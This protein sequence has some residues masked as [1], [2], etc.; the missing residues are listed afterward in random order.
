MAAARL[1]VARHASGPTPASRH[2]SSPADLV[3]HLTQLGT[4]I[5]THTSVAFI[6]VSPSCI[7]ACKLIRQGSRTLGYQPRSGYDQCCR[8]VVVRHEQAHIASTKLTSPRLS[9]QVTTM[10]RCR[11]R[12]RRSRAEPSRSSSSTWCAASP[13]P[14]FVPSGR[15][16]TPCRYLRRAPRPPPR[17]PRP[18]TNRTLLAVSDDAPAGCFS[19]SHGIST[20]WLDS[21]PKHQL[22]WLCHQSVKLD[23]YGFTGP[24]LAGPITHHR[25]RS[26]GRCALRTPIQGADRCSISAAA[27]GW[28]QGGNPCNWACLSEA[29]VE[30][31]HMS[32]FRFLQRRAA[33]RRRCGRRCGGTWGRRT[34]R[35][36]AGACGWPRRRRCWRPTRACSRRPGCW[37]RT[38]CATAGIMMCLMSSPGSLTSQPSVPKPSAMAPPDCNACLHPLC[39]RTL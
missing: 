7:S 3:H 24:T 19:N 9:V 35:S 37:R 8:H 14:R 32:L 6:S 1:R 16:P 30:I 21:R 2:D 28:A 36:T 22:L 17:R 34:R 13:R 23:A 12:A 20:D 26:A 11:W 10:R 38:R 25:T 15:R 29:P 4:L 31:A 39:K 33:A 27:G 18:S 5:R